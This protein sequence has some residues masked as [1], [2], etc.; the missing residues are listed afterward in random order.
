MFLTSGRGSLRSAQPEVRPG[1]F[2]LTV[3]VLVVA[4]VAVAGVAQLGSVSAAAATPASAPT[5]ATPANTP[6]GLT[7]AQ[8]AAAEAPRGVV[9][10]IGKAPRPSGASAPTATNPNC[11]S[12]SPPL[13]FNTG[14]PVAG[15]ESG[16]PGHVT[17]T[18]VFWAP[19]GY[20]FTATYKT[21][22]DTY[23]A[24][25]A[26]ASGT[27]GNVFSVAQEYYQNIGAGNQFINY[28]VTAG[29]EVDATDAY[30]AEGGR[31]GAPLKPG[32]V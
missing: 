2:R 13:I 14:Q 5:S 9:Y 32:S 1:R 12:C 25:V 15:G 27:N 4:V 3:G 30:P 29:A 17:I 28:K 10:P 19:T 20:S 6:S 8:Q 21:T 7:P 18:P 23:L 22:I 11:P 16:T 31:L 24:D 26:A